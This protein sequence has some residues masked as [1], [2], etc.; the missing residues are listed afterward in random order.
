MGENEAPS[1]YL[2]RIGLRH[3]SVRAGRYFLLLRHDPGYAGGFASLLPMA[4]IFGCPVE[5]GSIHPFRLE[6]HVVLELRVC[7][8]GYHIDPGENRGRG[9]S[10]PLQG[11][12]I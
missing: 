6:S 11:P 7:S 9:L 2:S 3:R 10:I 4:W 1:L 12:Q 8:T 5:A